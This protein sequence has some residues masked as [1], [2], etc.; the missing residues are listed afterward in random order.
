LNFDYFDWGWFGINILIPVVVPLAAL[1]IISL[2]AI[3]AAM[4][5]NIVIKSIGKGE[6]FW[7][8]MGMAA[9]A[10][11]DLDSF[12]TIASTGT[13]VKAANWATVCYGFM[14]FF[15]IAMVG[16]NSLEPVPPPPSAPGAPPPPP[17]RP[18]PLIPDKF[19][20][21]SSIICLLI[22]IVTYSAVHVK[23]TEQEEAVRKAA[24][25]KLQEC[26]AK[27]KGDAMHCVTDF[28]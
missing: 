20:F 21:G 7:A 27:A 22:V 19:I 24:I 16:L 17:P 25:I 5:K 1:Y 18:P 14:I 23:L 10:C 2:P 15:A 12:K 26:V 28:K 4:T 13:S 8:V 9:A 11:Y 6:L 3:I